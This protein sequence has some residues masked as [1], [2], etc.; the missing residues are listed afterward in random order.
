MLVDV[1]CF[2]QN[3]E[4]TN[5]QRC[6]LVTEMAVFPDVPWY[7]L[8]QID[9]ASYSHLLGHRDALSMQMQA[10]VDDADFMDDLLCSL[11]GVDSNAPCV[12]V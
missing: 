3:P 10:M 7:P 4:T 12:Q 9:R 11:P 6:L 8:R 1:G 2:G 5:T